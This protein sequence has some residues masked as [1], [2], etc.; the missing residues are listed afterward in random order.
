MGAKPAGSTTDRDGLGPMVDNC[1]SDV[2]SLPPDSGDG[3]GSELAVGEAA[4]EFVEA[5]IVAEGVPAKPG[6]C[7]T[8]RLAG[9]GHDHPDRA[10]D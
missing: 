9:V 2:R 5:E 4:G 10:P 1:G 8:A 7:I 6:Q 3:F